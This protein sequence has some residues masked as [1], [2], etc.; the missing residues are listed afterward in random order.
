MVLLI[1]TAKTKDYERLKA[2]LNYK[3]YLPI[4]LSIFRNQCSKKHSL[5]K[6]NIS[7]AKVC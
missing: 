3:G 1:L 2:N 7:P 6:R 5:D 4:L